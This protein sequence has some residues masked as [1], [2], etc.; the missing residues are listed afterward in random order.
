MRAR[1]GMC[2]LWLGTAMV[3]A[4]ETQLQRH[5]EVDTRATKLAPPPAAMKAPATLEPAR[6]ANSNGLYASL[7]GR[8]VNGA[9]FAVKDLT[10]KRDAA[11]I[12][13]ISGTV[14]LMGDVGGMTTGAVFLGEG[15]LRID[16]PS[17]M[18]KKQ[19][20]TVMKT[21]VLEQRFTSAVFEFTD[22]T[23]AELKKAA[24]LVATG[25]GEAVGQVQEA[26]SLFRHDLHYNVEARLL[27]DVARGGNGGYFVAVMKGALFS[28]RLIYMIDPH[29]A[30]RVAPEEVGLLTS[31]NE[32]YDVTLGFRSAE[33]RQLSRPTEN[34]AFRVPQ[35]TID[36]TIDKG[37]KLT[38]TVVTKVT[39]AD[40]GVK[41]LGLDIAPPLRVSGASMRPS[42]GTGRPTTTAQ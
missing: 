18:E 8:T 24:G 13:L 35:Q 30:L 15:V 10:L 20:K 2:L 5:P 28:K 14:Y 26:Q 39:A 19:L 7:R 16:P 27:E 1:V 4:Q 42:G 36:V 41:V 34:Y 6:A 40:D 9:A 23:G 32:G 22:G 33:E 25:A 17:A 38:G 29:G 12:T 37:G 11:E 21:D 31:S 3:W